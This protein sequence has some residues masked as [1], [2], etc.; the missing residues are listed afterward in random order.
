MLTLIFVALFVGGS[1]VAGGLLGFV[2][3]SAKEKLCGFFLALAAGIMLAAS[4]VSLIIPSLEGGGAADFFFTV[5]A[6]FLGS[7]AL[8]VAEFCLPAL[9]RL[10][11]AQNNR[12]ADRVLIFTCAIALHNL[13][14][15][16]AAGV[17]LGGGDT[18]E[19]ITLALGIALQNIP[20]G[21]VLISPLLAAGISPSR[22][23][24]T[25]SF[26]GVVE[27]FGTFAGYFFI[28]LSATALPFA[29]ALA[30]G[31]MLFV[32]CGEMLPEVCSSTGRFGTFS[33]IFGF[34]LMLGISFFL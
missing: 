1:T 24:L 14:E 5:F 30:G 29:L 13:P 7:A 21:M 10:L 22:T 27:I 25:A 18:A 32:I 4:I 3:K 6:I 28:N 23:L 34:C 17:G 11:P 9:R 31:C 16:I 33:V 19:G 20:E 15:G 8:C 12:R 2:F 26:T